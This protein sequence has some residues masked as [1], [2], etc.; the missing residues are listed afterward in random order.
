LPQVLESTERAMLVN[1]LKVHGNQL[2]IA[3]ALGVSQPTIARKLQ[4][5]GLS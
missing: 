5:Y 2:A 4:K 3:E 1:A